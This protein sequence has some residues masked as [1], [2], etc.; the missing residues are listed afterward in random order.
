LIVI[1]K[2][3]EEG[4]IAFLNKEYLYLGIWSTCFAIVLGFTVDNLEMQNKDHPTNFPFTATSFL[5][6]S[7]TSIVAGYIG[8]RVAVYTN[9]RVTFS[10]ATDENVGFNV[11][12]RGG[13]VLGFVLV[14]VALLMLM[15]IIIIFKGSWFDG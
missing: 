8:M 14:G 9:N 1:G 15:L 2:K 4:A 3:I 11:A 10:C 7:F 6:G 12:F 13:Q 5:I